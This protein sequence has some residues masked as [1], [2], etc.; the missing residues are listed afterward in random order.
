MWMNMKVIRSLLFP[1]TQGSSLGYI[2]KTQVLFQPWELQFQP[3]SSMS[4]YCVIRLRWYMK[5]EASRSHFTHGCCF[6][7][8]IETT[9]A[10]P[11]IFWGLKQFH[12]WHGGAN[13]PPC[14][15]LGSAS[16]TPQTRAPRHWS[17]P[18]RSTCWSSWWEKGAARWACRPADRPEPG[19][20]LRLRH[21]HRRRSAPE[22]SRTC[23]CERC[24]GRAPP[25]AGSPFGRAGRR[26]VTGCAGLLKTE[27][28]CTQMSVWMES[29]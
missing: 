6:L 27:A 12:I 17:G 13:T 11:L 18:E 5:G 3:E 28:S 4:V 1:L 20:R 14:G 23:S 9:S 7:A 15:R 19:T 25:T 24:P 16:V 8:R 29:R 2:L 10:A 21:C 26:L 22:R